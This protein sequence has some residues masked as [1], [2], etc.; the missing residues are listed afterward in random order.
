MIPKRAIFYWEG[1]EMTWLRQQS[2]NTFRVLNP[3]W[4]ID[5][6]HGD[7]IPIVGQTRLAIVGRSDWARYKALRSGG[8]VY[9]DTDIVFAKPIPEKW[10]EKE[11]IL[12][13]SDRC[14]LGHVALLGCEPGNKWA[15]MMDE[16]CAQ[17]VANGVPLNYQSLGIPLANRC[18]TAVQEYDI[19]WV[20]PDIF[21]PVVFT[22]CEYLWTDGIALSPMTI[23]VHWYGGDWTSMAMEPL[24]DEA[25]M[26][27]SKSMV[28]KAWRKAMKSAAQ[29]ETLLEQHGIA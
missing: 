2:M 14:S 8:G 18:I 19:Q 4:S 1:P 27:S 21:L 13:F 28:A 5:V 16:A 9:F 3:T 17:L 24:V 20:E 10:L 11:M 23:G 15:T 12:P 7:G 22:K 29:A 6:I 26:R 25:W